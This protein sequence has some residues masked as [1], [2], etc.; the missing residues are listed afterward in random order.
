MEWQ[1]I[2]VLGFLSGW[3]LRAIAL[4]I[5]NKYTKQ[6]DKNGCTNTNK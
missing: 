1:R 4:I 6:E 3:F 5:I 2:F